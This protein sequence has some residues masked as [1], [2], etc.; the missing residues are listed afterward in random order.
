MS[1]A[2]ETV[3]EVSP[4]LSLLPSGPL[5]PNPPS[6]LASAR[7]TSLME[8]LRKRYDL[9]LIDSPPVEHLADASILASISDGVIAVARVGVTKRADLPAAATNLRQVPTPLIGVVLLEPREIDD[10]YYPAV[11]RGARRIPTSVDDDVDDAS[12]RQSDAVESR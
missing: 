1:T 4:G 8:T 2:E 9:V 12:S 6:L 3:V 5:P 7:M 11:A 10:T